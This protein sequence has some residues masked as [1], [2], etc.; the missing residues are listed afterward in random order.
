MQ[1]ESR[2]KIEF[3]IE[4]N[5]R[6]IKS[7]D[8]KRELARNPKTPVLIQEREKLEIHHLL[9]RLRKYQSELFPF[10]KKIKANIKD[11]TEPTHVCAVY[12]LLC[13]VFENWNAFFLL[14][15]NGK[16]GAAGN[17]L[18]MIKEGDM[19]IQLFSV[20]AAQK[21]RTNL[22]KWLKGDI[23]THGI[24]REKVSEYYDKHSPV[25]EV[26][27]KK[28]DAHIYQ[29]E[30]QASHNSYATILESVSPFTGDFDFDGYTGCHRCL[31]LLRYAEGSLTATNIA[32]KAVYANLINE[33]AI[34]TQ[35]DTI[36]KK[37][38][39]DIGHGIDKGRLKG[40]LK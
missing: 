23:V 39:P 7:D 3:V 5:K 21:N 30:S 24:G 16:N 34:Y 11:I 1:D 40:F 27:V 32:M 36:L 15:E 9:S 19:T 18:R 37:Y 28:L 33:E 4:D 35:L 31:G 2:K 29:M 8:P 10:V 14:I 13:N 12:L 17:L 6:A 25:P 38:N 20:E 22:D 26:D